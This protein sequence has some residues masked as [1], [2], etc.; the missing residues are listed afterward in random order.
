MG[1]RR[2]INLVLLGVALVLVLV[3]AFSVRIEAAADRVA[4]LKAT[5]MSCGSCAGQITK[6]LEREAGVASVSVDLERGRVV[7][8]YDSKK[9]GPEGLATCV[10]RC[11]FGSSVLQVVSADDYRRAT[12]ID[13]GTQGGLARCSCCQ[14]NRKTEGVN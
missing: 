5:G 6:A 11:G 2:L 4:I 9:A 12:G 14:K 10:K 7:V 13:P 3:C 8:G 1:K